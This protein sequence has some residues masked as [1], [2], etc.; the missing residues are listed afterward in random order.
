MGATVGGNG[1]FLWCLENFSLAEVLTPEEHGE[2]VRRFGARTYRAGETVVAIGDPQT[3]IYKLHNGRVRLGRL[4]EEGRYVTLA[5]LLPGQ[6]FGEMALVEETASRW[7]VEAME[8]STICH[9]SKAELL[10]LANQNP[11]LTLRIAKLVGE[12]VVQLDSKLEDLLFRTVK[13][14]A[15]R[16]LLRLGDQCGVPV[17]GRRAVRLDLTLTHHELAQLIAASREATSAA[18]G[19]LRGEGVLTYESGTFVL[20]DLPGLRLVV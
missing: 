5:I 9:V 15:A 7:L 19:Q 20:T 10:R 3:T 18:L 12:R 4:S 6:M 1:Q 2:L 13:G 16:T 8:D 17:E 14:R 11:K